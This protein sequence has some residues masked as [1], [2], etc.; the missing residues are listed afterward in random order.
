MP[1]HSLASMPFTTPTVAPFDKT[2]IIGSQRVFGGQA[3]IGPAS[4]L[5]GGSKAL[6]FGNQPIP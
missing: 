4:R 6:E 1:M 3:P 5:V 2:S